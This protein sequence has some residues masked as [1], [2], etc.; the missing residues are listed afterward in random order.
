M[1][2]DG[3]RIS[4][5]RKG[6]LRFKSLI[7]AAQSAIAANAPVAVLALRMPQRIEARSH[8]GVESL[9]YRR[10]SDRALLQ[11]QRYRVFKKTLY[12]RHR[13]RRMTK[14]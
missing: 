7:G 3:A 14:C 12:Q 13:M 5:A 9:T 8:Q 4:S 6:K 11:S 10:G 2:D 1:A